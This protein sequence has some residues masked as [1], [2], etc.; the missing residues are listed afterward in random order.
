VPC[1]RCGK[2]AEEIIEVVEVVVETRDQV[3]DGIPGG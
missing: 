3:G 1:H 2:V